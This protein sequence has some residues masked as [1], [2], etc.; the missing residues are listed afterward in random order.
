MGICQTL[1]RD[2]KW[3]KESKFLPT[4]MGHGIQGPSAV[5]E[6]PACAVWQ[7]NVGDHTLRFQSI[8]WPVPSTSLRSI[9]TSFFNVFS[10]TIPFLTLE[11]LPPDNSN[12]YT[13]KNSML[14]PLWKTVWR[15]LLKLHTIDAGS[16]SHPKPHTRPPHTQILLHISILPSSVLGHRKYLLDAR[17]I[18]SFLTCTCC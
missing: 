7:A 17:K 9:L 11:L 8:L 10:P 18:T 14:V 3:T 6:A 13:Y 4:W 12:L 5:D 2:T 16:L 15:C 1:C